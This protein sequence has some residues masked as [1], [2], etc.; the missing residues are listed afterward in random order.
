MSEE[1]RH[2]PPPRE[3]ASKSKTMTDKPL[4]PSHVPTTFNRELSRKRNSLDDIGDRTVE[5]VA[6]FG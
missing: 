6:P 5:P 1:S 4:G 3:Q 2:Q